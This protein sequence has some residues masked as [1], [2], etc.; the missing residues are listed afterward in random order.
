MF[1]IAKQF[2]FDAAHLLPDHPGKCRTLHGHTYRVEIII[3][4]DRLNKQG[5]VMD[6]ADLA[7]FKEYVNNT[8]DHKYLND[9]I[10]LPTAENLAYHLFCKAFDLWGPMVAK[11]RVSETP[12]TWA[13]YER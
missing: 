12:N 2:T 5:M 4:R 8:L 6:Y 7:P 10:E 3:R 13:E 9:V 11:V 1:T